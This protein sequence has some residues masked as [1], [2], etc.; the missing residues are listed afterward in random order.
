MLHYYLHHGFV[1]LTLS[2]VAVVVEPQV[3]MAPCAAANPAYIVVWFNPESVL[4]SWV[5]VVPFVEV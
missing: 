2:K 4:P 5:H 3:V 1:I